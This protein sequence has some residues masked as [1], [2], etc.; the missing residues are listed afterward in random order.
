MSVTVRQIRKL[1]NSLSLLVEHPDGGVLCV[2][3]TDTSLELTKPHIEING[4]TPLFDPTNLLRL[5]ELIGT[6]Q[7][8][9]TQPMSE[10]I[11]HPEDVDMRHI[12]GEV[13]PTAPSP[14]DRAGRT[15][16]TFNQADSTIGGQDARPT[17]RGA[18]HPFQEPNK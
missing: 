12:Y 1:G 7:N 9:A 6:H 14:A 11:Q 2:P 10:G 15:H 4:Q 5:A 8:V 16:P 18:C 13:A 3:E 17:K